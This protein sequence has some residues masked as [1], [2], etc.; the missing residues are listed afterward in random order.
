MYFAKCR[1]YLVFYFKKIIFIC[2]RKMHSVKAKWKLHT[3]WKNDTN[4]AYQVVF[5]NRIT[6]INNRNALSLSQ[7]GNTLWT[8]WSTIFLPHF[9]ALIF[10]RKFIHFIWFVWHS[11]N[12]WIFYNHHKHSQKHR[13]TC[14]HIEKN[15][16]LWVWLTSLNNNNKKEEHWYIH[17]YYNSTAIRW[18]VFVCWKVLI[19]VSLIKSTLLLKFDRCLHDLMLYRHIINAVLC[20]SKTIQQTNHTH[21]IHI[22]TRHRLLF[23]AATKY[24]CVYSSL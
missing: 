16:R 6:I 11:Q 2:L 17:L 1:K 4:V 13:Y 23:I 10:A 3:S 8:K 12:Y 7:K 24:K 14:E 15:T 9:I 21:Q 18:P 19:F 22:I 5:L 20:Y